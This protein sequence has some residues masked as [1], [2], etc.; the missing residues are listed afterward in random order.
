MLSAEQ[1]SWKNTLNLFDILKSYYESTGW[2][3]VWA[4]NYKAISQKIPLEQKQRLQRRLRERFGENM[5]RIMK[6]NL[7]A[8]DYVLKKIQNTEWAGRDIVVPF[9]HK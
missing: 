8:S 6:E 9:S 7:M 3:G 2:E 5:K 4:K 1:H